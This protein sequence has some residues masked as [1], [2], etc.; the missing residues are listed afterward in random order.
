M[1]VHHR[2]GEIGGANEEFDVLKFT[3][4]NQWTVALVAFQRTTPDRNRKPIN[5]GRKGNDEIVVALHLLVR[6]FG[7]CS[8]SQPRAPRKRAAIRLAPCTF[9][10]SARGL[11]E[12]YPVDTGTLKAIAKFLVAG[13]FPPLSSQ[14]LR[15]TANLEDLFL[16]AALSLAPAKVCGCAEYPVAPAVRERQRVRGRHACGCRRAC[17]RCGSW[18]CPT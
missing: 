5:V 17:S 18:Q 10:C 12:R 2:P 15:R 6:V 14:I 4:W 1:G 7:L 13:H 16:S 11:V 9:D 3:Q 8:V